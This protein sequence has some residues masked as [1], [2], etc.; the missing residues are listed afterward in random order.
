MKVLDEVYHSLLNVLDEYALK[1][2]LPDKKKEELRKIF[3]EAYLEEKLA[4]FMGE[5]L[6]AYSDFLNF[7]TRVAL[8]GSVEKQEKPYMSITY[9]KQFKELMTING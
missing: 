5:K 2:Q 4:L 3:D 1:H 8:R 6:D 7:S 9:V